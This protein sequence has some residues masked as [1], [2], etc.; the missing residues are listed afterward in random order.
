MKSRM[1][2]NW[3]PPYPSLD[4]NYGDNVD[5]LTIAYYGVQSQQ[6]KNVDQ[7]AD[8]TNWF[9]KN[10]KTPHG[11]KVLERAKY[12]DN[13]G[14]E[15]TFFIAYWNNNSVYQNWEK[16]A[17]FQDYWNSE[18]RLNSSVGIW[19]EVLRIPRSRFETI[20]SSADGAGA[21]KMCSHFTEPVKEHAYWGAM[22]E[23]IPEAKTC[24]FHSTV[25]T[26]LSKPVK[27]GTRNKRVIV[28][29]PEN[30]AIIRSGQNYTDCKKVE[31]DYYQEHIVPAL[32]EGMEYI[33]TNPLDTGCCINRFSTEL[34]ENWKE[35]KKTFGAA[36]F[37]SLE[38]LEKWAEH[39]P[40]HLKIFGNFFGMAQHFNLK[41]DLKLWHEVS[42]LPKNN[43]LFEY[44]NCH[45]MTGLLPWF[46]T[47]VKT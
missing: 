27:R 21:A 43:Q 40:T 25:G 17:S 46:P 41:L 10:S 7:V 1:P 15:N 47:I 5:E 31:L 30:L 35:E 32:Y 20:F 33:A 36:Y 26:S 34:D 4:T 16:S 29:P 12:V 11:P 9:T 18:E 6:G 3:D 44:V 13:E 19:R 38:H 14:F 45:S 2:K 39:H 22:R 8:F 24:P 23:R 42:V 28:N 37:I